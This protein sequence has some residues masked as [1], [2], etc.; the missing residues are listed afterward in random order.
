MGNVA[1]QAR[2]TSKRA[3]KLAKGERDPG[4]F[5]ALPHSVLASPVLKLISANATKLFIDLLSQ[6]NGKNNGKLVANMGLMRQR[7]WRSDER[8]ANARIELQAAGLIVETRK[9]SKPNR[10]SWY[11]VTCF[12]L[13]VQDELDI[14]PSDFRRGR[15]LRPWEAALLAPTPAQERLFTQFQAQFGV[16]RPSAPTP[17]LGEPAPDVEADAALAAEAGCAD[18]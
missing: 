4:P 12:S 5:V 3:R 15:Y 6:Y 9:G 2:R 8:L 1:E 10:A 18:D 13:H 14:E 7:G 11:A 16:A 17:P